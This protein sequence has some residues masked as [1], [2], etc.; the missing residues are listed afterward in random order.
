M[1]RFDWRSKEIRAQVYFLDPESFVLCACL[2]VWC[3]ADVFSKD[4]CQG[5]L[6]RLVNIFP[7]DCIVV[8]HGARQ[9]KRS[10]TPLLA[11]TQTHA[12]RLA[13]A[14]LAGATFPRSIPSPAC[15]RRPIV[16]WLAAA[17]RRRG[18]RLESWPTVLRMVSI[19][20]RHLTAN[21][22]KHLRSSCLPVAL[23]LLVGFILTARLRH[24]LRL[25]MENRTVSCMC[26]SAHCCCLS[27]TF[28]C[29]VQMSK[30]PI[31][32]RTCCILRLR[33]EFVPESFLQL[34]ARTCLSFWPALEETG[35]KKTLEFSKTLFTV[36]YNKPCFLIAVQEYL[37]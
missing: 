1:C 17:L 31:S 34:Q 30:C 13:A 2:C 8:P 12:I 29:C 21:N 7:D 11:N 16:F 22:E 25:V 15:Q 32:V 14:P 4:F 23:F 37:A 5:S 24:W 18:W 6:V 3:L 20:R 28:H 26:C 27:Q 10:S 33:S 35:L 36:N 9:L 19:S